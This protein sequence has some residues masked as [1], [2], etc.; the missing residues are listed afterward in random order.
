[1][2]AGTI[3]EALGFWLGN[4]F[5]Y[6]YRS[7]FKGKQIEDLQKAK[8]CID[9]EIKRLEAESKREYQAMQEAPPPVRKAPWATQEYDPT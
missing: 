8:Q 4:S 7:E 1:M 2:E 5:K 9:M 3:C 6:V